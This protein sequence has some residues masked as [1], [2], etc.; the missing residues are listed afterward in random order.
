MQDSNTPARVPKI[1]ASSATSPYVAPIP[2]ASQ[3]GINPGRASW[4]DGFVPLNFLAVGAGGIPPFGSDANGALQQLSAGLQWLQ[5]GGPMPFDAAFSG[6]IGGYPA[7]ALIA[8][9]VTIGVWW[10]STA[11]NNTNNPDAGATT[12]WVQITLGNSRIRL[13]G[14]T[15]FFV[16]GAGGSDSNN[17]LTVGTAFQTIQRA[18]TVLQNLYDFNGFVATV[19]IAA[20]TYAAGGQLNGAIPGLTGP[21]SLLVTTSGGTVTVNGVGAAFGANQASMFALNSSALVLNCTTSGGLGAAVSAAGG[22]LIHILS[23]PTFGTCGTDHV[24]AATGGQVAYFAPETISGGAPN[25]FRSHSGGQIRANGVAA[26]LN[27]TPNFS[28]AFAVA[29]ECGVLEGV[30]YT[31]VSGTATGIRYAAISNGVI[32]AGGGGANVFPGNAAGSV[33]TGGQ[34][35]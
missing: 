27:G 7:G 18:F 3:I 12:N 21:S 23:T 4:A 20:G 33:A 35:L 19:S 13:F 25:H 15:S 8:S 31:V 9:A 10:L 29:D 30:G 11:D 22:S 1:W 34:Y 28:N 5:A 17:G 14:N 6:N 26:T 24:I 16:N 32:N 2:T